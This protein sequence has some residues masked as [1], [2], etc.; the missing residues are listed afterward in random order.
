MLKNGNTAL[1]LASWAGHTRV[2]ELLLDR[3]AKVNISSEVA[4]LFACLFVCLFVCLL[5]S[6]V[7]GNLFV[8]IVCL[9]VCLLVIGWCHSIDVGS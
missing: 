6:F 9:F 2:V 7:C 5:W 3:G 1:M 8:V 4:C